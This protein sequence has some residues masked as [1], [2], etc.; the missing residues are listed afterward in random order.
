MPLGGGSLFSGVV[1]RLSGVLSARRHPEQGR[2][3][4]PVREGSVLLFDNQPARDATRRPSKGATPSAA[5]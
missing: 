1:M 4:R 2:G 5:L 3:T